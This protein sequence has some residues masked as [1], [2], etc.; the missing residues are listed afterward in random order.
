MQKINYLNSYLF[1]I[2][3]RITAIL[4]IQCTIINTN[5]RTL[6]G[7]YPVLKEMIELYKDRI[8]SQLDVSCHYVF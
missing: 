4:H 5:E 6:S 3:C 7:K 1:V 2:S 8:H